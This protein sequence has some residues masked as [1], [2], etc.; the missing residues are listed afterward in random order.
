VNIEQDK[1]LQTFAFELFK[2]KDLSVDEAYDKAKEFLDEKRSKNNLKI[3]PSDSIK[4][5]A[6]THVGY[7]RNIVVDFNYFKNN[8]FL[9]DELRFPY[10][11]NDE[12]NIKRVV[13][14]VL[15][16]VNKQLEIKGCITSSV[17]V[18]LHQVR[19]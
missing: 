7:N 5:S 6:H 17:E 16:E 2:H 12:Q 4:I 3:V 19:D 10:Y 15:T 13:E 18:K 1:E 14:Y 11:A 8:S 9:I